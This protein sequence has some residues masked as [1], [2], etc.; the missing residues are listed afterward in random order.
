MPSS[1]P[2]SLWEQGRE[3]RKEFAPREVVSLV[4]ANTACAAHIRLFLTQACSL[5][6]NHS[7]E[8]LQLSEVPS[9]SPGKR[10]CWVGLTPWF[11]AQ[12]QIAI[13]ELNND[14][15]YLCDGELIS[16]SS[17]FTLEKWNPHSLLTHLPPATLL[18]E[19]L[20]QTQTTYSTGLCCWLFSISIAW[21]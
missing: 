2:I 20:L 1:F 14:Y 15:W 8:S 7:R 17:D 11:L 19:Q 13:D 16:I 4:E 12:N 6:A 3:G 21:L 9:K 10:L 18:T 5:Q